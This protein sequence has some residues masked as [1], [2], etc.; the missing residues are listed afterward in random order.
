MRPPL[1]SGR[2]RA[3]PVQASFKVQFSCKSVISAG[4][5]QRAPAQTSPAGCDG[6]A[7]TWEEPAPDLTGGG[8]I[9]VELSGRRTIVPT[10]G[11]EIPTGTLHSI[12]RDLGL[13][14]EPDE[15]VPGRRASRARVIAAGLIDHDIGRLI[16]QA[17]KELEPPRVV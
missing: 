7:A 5:E 11:K 6:S 17:Q 9:R 16:K 13:R 2:A 4:E 15:L 12:L 10:G 1:W 3:D 8:H 14:L